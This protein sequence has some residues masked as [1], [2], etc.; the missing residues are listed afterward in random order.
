MRAVP[1]WRCL[2]WRM[3]ARQHV[4]LM[5]RGLANDPPRS[6]HCVE[7]PMPN[8]GRVDPLVSHP[9]ASGVHDVME[10]PRHL[11]SAFLDRGAPPGSEPMT[12]DDFFAAERTRLFGALAVMSGNRAEAEEVM[13]EAFLRVWERW[14]RVAAMDS[15]T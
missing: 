4:T 1:L 10:T 7:H 8:G 14:D 2:P 9:R 15:P 5:D 6:R 11:T 12:F 13:Q 3:P